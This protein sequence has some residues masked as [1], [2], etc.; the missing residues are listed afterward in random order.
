MNTIAFKVPLLFSKLVIYPLDLVLQVSYATILLL[1]MPSLSTW[2]SSAFRAATVWL[3]HLFV[4]LLGD[5]RDLPLLGCD[6][7]LLLLPPL[8][9][10]QDFLLCD[11]Y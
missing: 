3:M 2:P 9:L 5:F 4:S 11:T 10:F 1:V 8:F 7:D 6:P